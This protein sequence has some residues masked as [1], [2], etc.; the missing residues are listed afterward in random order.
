MPDIEEEQEAV[1]EAPREP[2]VNND[3]NNNLY[4][5][6][7]AQLTCHLALNGAAELPADIHALL[8]QGLCSIYNNI[9]RYM[10]LPEAMERAFLRYH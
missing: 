9:D 7:Q 8:A 5:Q 2:P 10:E 3:N 6:P 1:P 4:A